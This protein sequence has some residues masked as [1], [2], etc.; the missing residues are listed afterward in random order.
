MCVQCLDCQ[1]FDVDRTNFRLLAAFNLVSGKSPKCLFERSR[2]LDII[3]H[4]SANEG[5]LDKGV[6]YKATFEKVFA[7][8]CP[9]QERNSSETGVLQPLSLVSFG[10][11]QPFKSRDQEILTMNV[12]R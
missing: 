1:I 9:G 6:P 2:V 11:A 12:L 7:T 4:P 8:L 10:F 3:Y 5:S